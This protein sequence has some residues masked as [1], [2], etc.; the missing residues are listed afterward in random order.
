MKLVAKRSDANFEIVWWKPDIE[1]CLHNDR[2]RRKVDSKITIENIEFEE[3]SEEL[4]NK[5]KIKVTKKEV[6]KKPNWKVWA[7]EKGFDDDKLKSSSWCLG[8]TSGNCWGD[9]KSIISSDPQ[10]ISFTEFDN[11]LEKICP[12]IGFLQYKKL[13]NETVTTEIKGDGDY[14]GGYVEYANY[15]CNLSKLNEMLIEMGLI[16]A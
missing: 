13:Y 4:V 1:S 16:K 14:Y 2:G 12:A 6:V 9:E 15:I 11:L 5:Y 8:G 3:P 10:P 7:Q